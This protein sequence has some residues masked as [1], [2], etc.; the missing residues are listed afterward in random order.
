MSLS[1]LLGMVLDYSSKLRCPP[2]FVKRLPHLWPRPFPLV[3]SAAHTIGRVMCTESSRNRSAWPG[4]TD[5]QFANLNANSDPLG[6]LFHSFGLP[7]LLSDLTPNVHI[8]VHSPRV[9]S[10]TCASTPGTSSPVMGSCRAVAAVKTRQHQHERIG[11]KTLSTITHALRG[12]S[13]MIRLCETSRSLG[14]QV[15]V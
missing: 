4:K 8:L 14:V 5:N 15:A 1:M 12:L 6:W 3:S 13:W 11:P 10:C 7:R 2:E 9:G